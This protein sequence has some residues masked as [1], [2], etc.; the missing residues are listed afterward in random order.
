MKFE[1]KSCNCTCF[2]KQLLRLNSIETCYNLVLPA[3]YEDRKPAMIK[4][5]QMMP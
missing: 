1:E 5:Q 4:A 3:V 2:L